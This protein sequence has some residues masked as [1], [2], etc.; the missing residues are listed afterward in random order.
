M[1]DIADPKD[2]GR[3]VR[4]LRK[5]RGWGQTKLGEVAGYSQTNI[6]WIEK[7]DQKDPTKHAVRLADALGSTPDW[8]LYG[9]G[10]R[11]TG[12]RPMTSQQFQKVYESL[13]IEVQEMLTKLVRQHV[14]IEAPAEKK[15]RKVG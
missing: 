14:E 11:T 8:L 12:I 6:G 9:R 3:R 4:E 13:P 2:F 5:E 1:K 10:P 7:G 15:S